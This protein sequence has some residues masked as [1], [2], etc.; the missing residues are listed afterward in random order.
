MSEWTLVT[1][2]IKVGIVFG[3]IGMV[4][5]G[6]DTAL[7]PK[8]DA[9]EIIYQA[10]TGFLIGF[11]VG[12][13]ITLIGPVAFLKIAPYLACIIAFL[14]GS[15]TYDSFVQGN[16]LQGIFR[17]FLT[18]L[19]V[20]SLHPKTSPHLVK[21]LQGLKGR[22]TGKAPTAI[23]SL[24]LPL[25]PTPYPQ[26][27]S[28]QLFSKNLSAGEYV[29]G[30]NAE[31]QIWVAEN[32]HH[33]HPK[34]FGGGQGTTAAETVK[35]SSNGTVTELTNIS[36]TFQHPTSTLTYVMEAIIRQGGKITETAIKPFI[37]YDTPPEQSH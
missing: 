37:F 23:P 8:A 26:H 4:L 20:V 35:I 7:D 5:S 1:Q 2:A 25:A 19:V 34:I 31:G 14:G 29:Y 15:A 33:M 28:S 17:L 24:K 13:L 3:I 30:M 36:G 32:I 10:G 16:M 18:V 6:V 11:S 21:F 27:S 9:G 22:I 12:A